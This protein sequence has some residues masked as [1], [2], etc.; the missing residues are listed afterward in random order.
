LDL[1]VR[2]QSDDGGWGP[3]VN[4]PSDVFDTALVVLAL[5]ITTRKEFDDRISRGRKYLIDT[6]EA[7]GGWPATTRPPGVDS[8]AQRISTTAWATMAL[9]ATRP[10]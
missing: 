9:L 5:S 3:F 10:K 7:D 4:S 1:I 8:Y 6:Q 2:G